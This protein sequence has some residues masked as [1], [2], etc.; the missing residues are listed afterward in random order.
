MYLQVIECLKCHNHYGEKNKFI[1]ICPFCGNDDTEQT[2]YLDE[3]SNIRKSFIQG[4]V[5]K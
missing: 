2:I 1:P 4:G 3:T 5:Q